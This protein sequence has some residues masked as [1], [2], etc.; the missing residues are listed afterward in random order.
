[1]L[2]A[3]PQGFPFKARVFKYGKK[4]RGTNHEN[5]NGGS[6]AAKAEAETS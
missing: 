6:V 1:M 4:I 3:E 5:M 2:R